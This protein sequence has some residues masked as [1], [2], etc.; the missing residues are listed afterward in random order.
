MKKQ[1][2]I[3]LLKFFIGWP[4]S[5]IAL[6]FV[7][8]LLF[9][10]TGEVDLSSISVNYGSLLLSIVFFIT[11]FFLRS[12][13]WL[14]ILHLQGH[15]PSFKTSAYFWGISELKRYV[16]GNI[17]SFVGRSV[18]FTNIGMTK[19]ELFTAFLLEGEALTIASF[20]LSLFAVSFTT[21]Q[22]LFFP[23]LS[24]LIYSGI[25]LS[26]VAF[27]FQK[28]LLE[29]LTRKIPY[30]HHAISPFTWKSHLSLL[31]WNL[32]SFTFFALGYYFS[33]SSI[34]ILPFTKIVQI[35]SFFVM[36]YVI[37]YLSFLTPSGLG[38][39][40]GTI[41]LGLV[42]FATKQLAGYAALLSR[43]VLIFSE[44]IFTGI[45]YLL[46]KAGESDDKPKSR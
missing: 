39:R 46:H 27:V 9:T 18:L 11:Y 7:F 13:S 14:K 5:I 28:E 40:E 4:L 21:E 16:P 1:S 42:S 37:G 25:F 8:K 38:V 17:W 41:A 34:I 31:F 3:T 19:K 35:S 20:V 33:I 36:A 12:T 15:Y 44:L 26:T 24:F 2:F 10:Q 30:I 29:P 23:A 43:V 32:L 6:F 22:I 45:V